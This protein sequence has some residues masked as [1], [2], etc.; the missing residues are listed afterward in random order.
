MSKIRNESSVYICHM[1]LRISQR[2]RPL[3]DRLDIL[4]CL[5]E[6]SVYEDMGLLKGLAVF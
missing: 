2:G 6:R 1:S 3:I 5:W 4:Q